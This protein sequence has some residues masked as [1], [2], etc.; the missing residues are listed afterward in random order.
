MLLFVV[1]FHRIS[2]TSGQYNPVEWPNSQLLSDDLHEDKQ[3]RRQP[4]RER[5]TCHRSSAPEWPLERVTILTIAP[6]ALSFP[7]PGLCGTVP[8]CVPYLRR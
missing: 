1:P 6:S 4:E 7:F 3:E 8:W 2:S 5:G